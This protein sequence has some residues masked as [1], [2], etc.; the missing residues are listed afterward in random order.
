M[1]FGNFLEQ[2][3]NVAAQDGRIGQ[4][5]VD[6]FAKMIKEEFAGMRSGLESAH[7]A[8]TSEQC[9]SADLSTELQLWIFLTK[10]RRSSS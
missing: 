2:S 8:I 9:V 7:N 3:A 4:K 5:R 1:G 6:E 10:W